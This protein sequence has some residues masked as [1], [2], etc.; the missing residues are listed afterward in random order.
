PGTANLDLGL[1]R[2]FRI[3]ERMQLQFRAEVF[4]FT[5]TPHFQNP[6]GN[7]SNMTLNADGSIRSLG[8]YTVITAV[9]NGG[10]EG[11]DE[12]VFRFGVR[13]SF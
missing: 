4:N 2:N 9:K 12:R 10:R 13:L 6:G 11:V 5:N 1:F 8:G 3:S 7:V